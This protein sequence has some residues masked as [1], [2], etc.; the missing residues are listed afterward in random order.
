MKFD[1]GTDTLDEIMI[2]TDSKFKSS[3]LNQKQTKDH[4]FM[5]AISH[6]SK[7]QSIVILSTFQMRYIAIRKA[8]K[9]EV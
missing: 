1:V 3:K 6:S 9:K 7:L 4:V 2:F 8:K 5:L